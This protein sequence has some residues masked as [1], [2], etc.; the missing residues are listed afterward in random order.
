[1]PDCLW[2]H[3]MMSTK[4]GQADCLGS[5]APWLGCKWMS[6]CMGT[7]EGEGA[8][9]REKKFLLFS[10]DLCP[11]VST[12]ICFSLFCDVCC[13]WQKNFQWCALYAA[14]MEG[15]NSNL[16]GA[17]SAYTLLHCPQYVALFKAVQGTVVKLMHI[18]IDNLY[19][20]CWH[21]AARDAWP[22]VSLCSWCEP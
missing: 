8:K 14:E 5:R 9:S 16:E 20:N 3:P 2:R 18:F 15:S 11:L 21:F 10:Y 19:A 12:E 22:I 4:A 6:E 13:V 1:M 7:Y 17:P